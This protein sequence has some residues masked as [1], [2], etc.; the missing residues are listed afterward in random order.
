MTVKRRP[1]RLSVVVTGVG[2][3]GFVAGCPMTGVG[4]F[5]ATRI[6]GS[7]KSRHGRRGL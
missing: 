6:S 5:S 1:K 4:D 3:L 2:L 7:W